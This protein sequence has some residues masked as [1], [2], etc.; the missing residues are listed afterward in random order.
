MNRAIVDTNF[1]NEHFI[2]KCGHLISFLV[3]LFHRRNVKLVSPVGSC[4]M[5]KWNSSLFNDFN[6]I[7]KGIRQLKATVSFH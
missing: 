7:A 1:V 4:S 2:S 3:S 5:H 6:I